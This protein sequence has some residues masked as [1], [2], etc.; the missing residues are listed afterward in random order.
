[1][2]IVSEIQSRKKSRRVVIVVALIVVSALTYTA[3][4]RFFVQKNGQDLPYKAYEVA[5][6]SVQETIS[7]DG[8][9]L[10]RGYYSLGFPIAGKI[11]SIYKKD[12][13]RVKKGESLALLDDSYARI[14]LEKANIAL[15]NARANLVAKQ[16]T[17]PST[18]DVRVA[19][20]QL[21][22]AI[23][24][25][26]NTRRQ[27]DSDALTAKKS[28]E[29]ALVSLRSA[30]SDLEANRA[31]AKTSLQNSLNSVTLA[32]TELKNAETDLVRVFVDGSG[33]LRD[34]REKGFLAI[35]TLSQI[36]GKDL[37]DVDSLLG[38]TN[39]NRNKNDAYESYLGAKDLGGKI[40]AESVFQS[41]QSA[42]DTFL[43]DW[44][45]IHSN[46]PYV[47]VVSRMG[48][49]Y[50]ISGL[51]SD[52]LTET[53]AVLKNSIPASNFPQTSIDAFVTQFDSE[54]SAL[55]TQNDVFITARQAIVTKET[56]LASEEQ[57]RQDAIR[58]LRSRLDL[59]KSALEKTK[60][61]AELLLKASQAKLDLAQKQVESSEI[62]Y[63]AMVRHGKD[64]IASAS[65]QVDIARAS[66]DV[67]KKRITPKELAPY[68]VAIRTAQNAVEEAKKR[69]QNTVLRSPA[70]GIITKVDMLAGE[71]VSAGK[72]FISLVDSTH[73]YIESNME[74]IDVAKVRV[75]QPVNITFDALEGVSL[76]GSVTF[77]SPSSSIDANGI[78]TYRVNI[79]FE[80]GTA[81]VRE[82][83]SATVEY[84]VR[85]AENVLIVP[86]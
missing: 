68:E 19:E 2:T 80:P 66:V 39:V 78:V 17:A 45:R 53:L 11:A 83:M 5:S 3:Y 79:A 62:Q 38:V 72:P 48:A 30:E 14:D 70:D 1:M 59:A 29:T 9:A 63:T 84:I 81:G 69:L 7:G 64:S 40:R 52:T 34:L 71:E 50:N 10:Y 24:T 85:K 12:G 82:G 43:A 36:L 60:S 86:V 31:D 6:G 20:E 33:S 47:E 56:N 42:F 41:T 23:I 73:P 35:D 49:L 75:G 74:E 22:Q 65:N 16:A 55:K 46:P 57:S 61:N 44:N 26:E 51:V 21:R 27:A 58:V 4:V 54:L 67:K 76:T 28:T 77:I 13:E 37:Y 8:K 18:E 25:L 15:E 32:E